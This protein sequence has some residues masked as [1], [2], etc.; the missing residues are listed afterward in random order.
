MPLRSGAVRTAKGRGKQDGVG[1]GQRHSR[2]GLVAR[3]ARPA[4]WA[5][6]CAVRQVALLRAL[7]IP[8]AH[9]V[10]FTLKLLAIQSLRGSGF[11]TFYSPFLSFFLI[12]FPLLCLEMHIRDRTAQKCPAGS[13]TAQEARAGGVPGAHICPCPTAPAGVCS[14]QPQGIFAHKGKCELAFCWVRVIPSS[15]KCMVSSY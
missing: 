7:H 4:Q 2:K 3:F 9:I 10:C 8:S 15:V 5:E 13:F 1:K 14:P 11:F 12:F 6:G